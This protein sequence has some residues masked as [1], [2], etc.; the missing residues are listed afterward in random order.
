[1]WRKGLVIV[2]S[3][4][5]PPYIAQIVTIGSDLDEESDYSDQ[6]SNSPRFELPECC[7]AV[8]FPSI[9]SNSSCF[10]PYVYLRFCA[11]DLLADP[12]VEDISVSVESNKPAAVYQFIPNSC[13]NYYMV[14][15]LRWS[16]FGFPPQPC[17]DDPVNYMITIEGE[18]FTLEAEGNISFE[19]CCPDA[20]E[21]PIVPIKPT[22]CDYT[23]NDPKGPLQF[24]MAVPQLKAIVEES[25]LNGERMEY[26]F[27]EKIDRKSILEVKPFTEKI[28][29]GIPTAIS[30][31]VVLNQTYGIH[32][33]ANGKVYEI[34]FPDFKAAGD[35]HLEE[36]SI[37]VINTP[38]EHYL[39]ITGLMPDYDV[40]L[41]DM[42]GQIHRKYNGTHYTKI[43]LDKYPSGLYFVQITHKDNGLIHIRKL[44]KP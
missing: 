4:G 29:G 38:S 24:S 41:V 23:I 15:I 1:M 20:P 5:S 39:Q 8:E 9:R 33:L 14:R 2:D 21:L 17:N 16:I 42:T 19:D 25:R 26:L 7:A 37:L 3:L 22:V 34:E 32:A 11:D 13:D 18:G 27:V 40:S 43:D 6:N 10:S 35:I 44:L 31:P 12:C 30:D 28:T 36:N